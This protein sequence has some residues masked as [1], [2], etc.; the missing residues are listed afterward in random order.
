MTNI[1][2]YNQT[3]VSSF[4]VNEQQ[5][6]TLNYQSVDGWDSIGHMRMIAEL[7]EVFNIM[8][9]TDDI[10]DFSSY[11]KGFK[12]LKKYGIEL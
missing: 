4:S 3:F 10:L 7:E 9:E 8:I 2:K 1:E 11:S 5:L 6:S 12:I